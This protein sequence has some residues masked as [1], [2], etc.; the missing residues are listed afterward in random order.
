MGDKQDERRGQL[1]VTIAA[2]LAKVRGQMT[3]AE[4]GRLLAEVVRTAER[5]AEIDAK[6]VGR[7]TPTVPPDEIRRLLDLRFS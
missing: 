1:M 6:P 2:R 4:F 7:L 3:D 5:F